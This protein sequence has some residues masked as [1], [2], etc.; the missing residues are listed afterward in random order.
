MN[1]KKSMGGAT[2]KKILLREERK[3]RG[4]KDRSEV[5]RLQGSDSWKRG[6]KAWRGT[7]GIAQEGSQKPKES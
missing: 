7:K 5:R 1:S 2:R 4:T 6:G 3:K